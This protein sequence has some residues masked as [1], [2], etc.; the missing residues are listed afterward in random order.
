MY[1]EDGQIVE[2]DE[3]KKAVGRAD[4]LIIAFRSFAERLLVD[5]RSNDAAGPLVQVVEPLAGVEERMFWL[6]RNRPQFGM[7]Q[8]FTFFVWP[9][10]VEFL[11]E[12]GVTDAIRATV[13][14]GDG[15]RQL[16]HAVSELAG[17][18]RTARRAAIDG[19]RPWR[20][21][22]SAQGTPRRG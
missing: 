19:P 15:G 8:R 16:E 20:T 17:R 12:T 2:I 5:S 1:G 10:S 6:G 14:E 9:H 13:A 3:V 21:L 11:T 7:P 22:W 18:E 4:V